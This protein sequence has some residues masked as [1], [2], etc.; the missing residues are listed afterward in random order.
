MLKKIILIF[1]EIFFYNLFKGKEGFV[2]NETFLKQMYASRA[3][4]DR[5]RFFKLSTQKKGHLETL[6]GL[7]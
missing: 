3:I 1:I 4:K 5:N 7:S 6:N 2:S